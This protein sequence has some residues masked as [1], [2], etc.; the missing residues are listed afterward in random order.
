MRRIASTIS[1]YKPSTTGHATSLSVAEMS[2]AKCGVPCLF[3]RSGGLSES[4]RR[5]ASLVQLPPHID[6]SSRRVLFAEKM[7]FGDLLAMFARYTDGDDKAET[8]RIWLYAELE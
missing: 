8:V 7:N 2:V 4:G 6:K 3:C 5:K 1:G